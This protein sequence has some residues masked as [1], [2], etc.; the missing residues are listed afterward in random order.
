MAKSE[1][2][3][4]V[5]RVPRP[6]IREL[7]LQEW[8]WRIGEEAATHRI[9]YYKCQNRGWIA[10]V[11]GF[12]LIL[13]GGFNNIPA[14]VGLGIAALGIWLVFNMKTWIEIV[15][16]H[17]SASTALGIRLGMRSFPPRDVDRYRAWCSENGVQPYPFKPRD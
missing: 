2:P 13:I 17:R 16:M 14:V 7:V 11:I 9:E 8:T 10:S 1:V 12:V 5:S 15:R 3:S 6:K 4:T